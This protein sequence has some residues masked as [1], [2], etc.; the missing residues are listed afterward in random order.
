MINTLQRRHFLRGT[1][2][3][4][5]LPALE[6]LGFQRFASAAPVDAPPKRMAFLSFG[7]GVTRE[8]WFP[9]IATT[10]PTYQLS[11]GLA[12]LQRHKQDFSVI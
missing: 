6:S 10:G 3:L 1:G 2:A 5:A 8:S 9:D 7:W 4:I 12:P 11:K